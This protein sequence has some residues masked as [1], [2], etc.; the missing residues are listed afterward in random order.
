MCDE[1]LSLKKKAQISVTVKFSPSFQP[2]RAS[3]IAHSRLFQMFYILEVSINEWMSSSHFLA[4]LKQQR[5][6]P[7]N[8]G[9][10]IFLA[11][12]FSLVSSQ[13]G[14][15]TQD[16]CVT[17]QKTVAKKHTWWVK[18][19]FLQFFHLR[20]L[21]CTERACFS[22]QTFIT[23]GSVLFWL[24]RRDLGGKR[25]KN[26]TQWKRV[27]SLRWNTVALEEDQWYI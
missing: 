25:K 20:Y 26:F 4:L 14:F 6:R 11:W 16:C 12:H 10:N 5:E 7:E 3:L 24:F 9:L 13:G 21:I 17:S 19:N 27:S 23:S 8:S 2:S 15:V 22:A 1:R 18:N